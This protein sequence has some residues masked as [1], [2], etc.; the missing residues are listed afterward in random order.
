MICYP[1]NILNLII[2]MH[3][4]MGLFLYL[5][6]H[7]VQISKK[8]KVRKNLNVTFYKQLYNIVGKE[9]A[10][11]YIGTMQYILCSCVFIM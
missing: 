2:S 5:L 4:P 1:G 9:Q 6:F 11:V 7:A 3:I 10:L 8:K